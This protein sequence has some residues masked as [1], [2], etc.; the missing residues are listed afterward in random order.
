[1]RNKGKKSSGT[2]LFVKT[3]GADVFLKWRNKMSSIISCNSSLKKNMEQILW[4]FTIL[5]LILAHADSL[6]AKAFPGAEGYAA[7]ITG[8]RGGQV[9]RVTNLD[10]SGAG[11][12]Q[13]ALS[14]SGPRIIIFD[15]S[16]VIEADEIVIEHGDFTLAGE[17]A[18][19]G[20]ITIAGRLNSEYLDTSVTNF[21]IRHIRIRPRALS[22]NQGDSIR[23]ANNSDFILDHISVSWGADETI[24]AYQSHDFTI[25]WSTIE[26]SATYAGHP[27]GNFHNYGFING[28]AGSN[29]SLHH[30]IF[31][32]HNKRTPAVANG[33]SDIV[34]NVIYNFRN[35][36]NHHN[37]A[38]TSGFNFIGNYYKAGPDENDPVAIL[39]DD[40]DNSSGAYYYVEDLYFNGV[41]SDPWDIVA[42]WPTN[43]SPP[44]SQAA[45][46]F[47]TPSITTHSSTEAYDLTLEQSGAWPRDTVTLRTIDEIKTGTGSWGRE[48]PADLMEGLTPGTPPEDT[49]GDGMPDDWE[50]NR[51]LDPD[52]ADNNENDDG[53]EYTNIEEYLHYRSDLLINGIPSDLKGDVNGDFSVNLVDAIMSLKIVSG[54]DQYDSIN[55]NSDV[56]SDDRI[57]LVEAVYILQYAASLR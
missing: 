22:G 39:V 49:D 24:D 34:N 3:T 25:Q 9:I 4:F 43:M 19:G 12:L 47:N 7:D 50:I 23:I 30:N 20:G 38:D 27:D 32:H 36:F 35:G 45:S 31:A 15:V 16:G 54:H 57:G 41:A 18:P 56:N 6:S 28:P 21:I 8:G 53:D 44:P 2:N 46:R 1:M 13:A 52:V 10:A 37:P 33:M 48:V 42:Y 51:G 29:V 17:T 26:E 11:S 5:F 40:E 14:V 55:S